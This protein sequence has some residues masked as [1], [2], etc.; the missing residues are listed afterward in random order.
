[1]RKSTTA[2]YTALLF[3]ILS[4]DA[5]KAQAVSDTIV[6][7]DKMKIVCRTVYDTAPEPTFKMSTFIIKNIRF[8]DEAR[9]NNIEGK[10]FVSYT[11]DESGNVTEPAIVSSPHAVLSAEVLRLVS[12]MPKWKPAIKD[13]KPVK[14]VLEMPI[15][16]QFE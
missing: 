15:L 14:A 5:A 8:P 11:I 1:M 9:E 10:V 2:I 12:L 6:L 3:V 4:A 7:K 13:N 16:F